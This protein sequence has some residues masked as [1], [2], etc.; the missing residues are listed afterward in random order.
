MEEEL[1]TLVWVSVVFVAV[2]PVVVV[3]VLPVFVVV[4]VLPV[5]AFLVVAVF[6]VSVQPNSSEF[7]LALAFFLLQ[8][9]V[10]FQRA[11]LLLHPAPFA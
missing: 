1:A 8:L 10:D 11:C 9:L 4:V 2:F 5:V 3:V 6:V 7:C